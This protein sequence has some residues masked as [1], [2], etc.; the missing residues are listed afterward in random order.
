MRLLC[1]FLATLEP[2][3]MAQGHLSKRF[4][5]QDLI[6]Q[7]P[8]QPSVCCALPARISLQWAMLVHRA[9]IVLLELISLTAQLQFVLFARLGRTVLVLGLL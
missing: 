9:G 5:L 6:I 7:P 4:A 3:V 2:F 8:K 1:A